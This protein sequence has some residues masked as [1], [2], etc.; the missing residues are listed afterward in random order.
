M[1]HARHEKIITFSR[2]A[3][4]VPKTGQI[5]RISNFEFHNCKAVI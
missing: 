1:K 2:F 5:Y 3:A 4:R